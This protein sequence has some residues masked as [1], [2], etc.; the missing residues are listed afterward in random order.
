MNNLSLDI[1]LENVDVSKLDDFEQYHLSNLLIHSSKVDA[2]KIIIN[3][4]EGDFSQLSPELERIAIKYYKMGGQVGF[5][6]SSDA[7]GYAY[8]IK[9]HFFGKTSS[10]EYSMSLTESEI[11]DYLLDSGYN[12]KDRGRF[13][14]MVIS[15][16]VD[17]GV[18]LDMQYEFE[19]GGDVDVSQI[20]AL[21]ENMGGMGAGK[22]SDLEVR[23]EYKERERL[24][25]EKERK[26][27]ERAKKLKK[28]KGS[29]KKG[30]SNVFKKIKKNW[31]EGGLME[32]GYMDYTDY[33]PNYLDTETMVKNE[34]SNGEICETRLTN[35][36]GKKPNYPVQIVGSLSLKKC[37]LR[38]YYKI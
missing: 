34:L 15:S 7:I 14:D 17:L 24:R 13:F 35:I 22:K 11:M 29:V 10:E 30:F 23:L 2:L 1:E 6:T 36:L 19:N 20:M 9:E 37:F 12:G 28:F 5:E 18:N 26:E 33:S 4:T 38:P 16:L 8:N 32:Y 31:D 21:T 3:N 27:R 25:K